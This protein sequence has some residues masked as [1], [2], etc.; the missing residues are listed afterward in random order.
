MKNKLKSFTLI[1]TLIATILMTLAL[2]VLTH[3]VGYMR[4]ILEI[5]H[6]QD[7][8]VNALQQKLAEIA[9]SQIDQVVS[10]YDGH[11]FEVKDENEE[12]LLVPPAGQ[13]EV[14]LV[15][16][17]QVTG[18]SNLYNVT[19]TVTWERFGRTTTR[20]ISTVFGAKE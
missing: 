12:D 5:S 6:D 13:T 4:N 1:E 16:A 8:A 11:T 19:V 3:S 15:A 7:I 18:V 14:G 10:N 17:S 9:N 20:S 2:G